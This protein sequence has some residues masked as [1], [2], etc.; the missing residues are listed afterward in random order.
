MIKERCLYKSFPNNLRN[1]TSCEFH[2]P[3][4]KPLVPAYVHPPVTI[5]FVGENP[6]WAEGQDLPFADSTISG[7]ALIINYM[8]GAAMNY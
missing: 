5:M 6:S 8:M 1:C 7:N 4:I 2:N 3:G